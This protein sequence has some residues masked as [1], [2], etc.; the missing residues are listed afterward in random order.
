MLLAFGNATRFKG[1]LVWLIPVPLK[2]SVSAFIL[3]ALSPV[4]LFFL[5][6]PTFLSV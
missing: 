3:E 2:C 4:H 6:D 5:P 1:R